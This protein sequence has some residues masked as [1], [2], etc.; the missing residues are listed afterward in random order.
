MDR[1]KLWKRLKKIGVP[2]IRPDLAKQDALVAY[3]EHLA[4]QRS[5]AAARLDKGREAAQRR[6]DELRKGIG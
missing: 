2:G 3:A 6:F 4:Y 1:E 5:L